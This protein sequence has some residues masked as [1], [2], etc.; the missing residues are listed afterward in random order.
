MAKLH[1]TFETTLSAEKAFAFVADFSNSSL[2][3]PGVAWSEGLTSGPVRVGSAYRLGVRFGSRVAP[4][5]YRITTLDP[6]RRVV[7][8]GKGSGVEATD[9]I[10]FEPLATGTRVDYMAD[11]RLR[12]WL[13]LVAPF[14]GRAIAAIGRNGRAGM[15]KTLEEM[16][17]EAAPGHSA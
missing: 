5:E 8:E 15:L 1:E 4:M 12:G 16:A 3:D 9:D 6:G 10:R 11:I 14:A 17:R 2:W 13:R 7:L